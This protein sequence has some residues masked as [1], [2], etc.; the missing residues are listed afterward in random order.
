[1]PYSALEAK[2]APLCHPVRAIADYGNLTIMPDALD[3]Y[4]AMVQ[5]VAGRD[6]S[7]VTRYTTNAFLHAKLG[8]A[9]TRRN[10]APHIF[11]SAEEAR[12][13]FKT[14]TAR[15]ARKAN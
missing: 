6:T 11:E 3:A 7:G 14:L 12:E 5:D 2:L 8:E 10:L 1:M 9:L 4:T 13:H 15:T